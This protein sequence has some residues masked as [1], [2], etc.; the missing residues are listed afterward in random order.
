MRW[1]LIPS[2]AKDPSVAA[3][4]NQC[5]GRNGRHQTRVPRC[6]EIP[7]V[8]DPRRWFL[9]VDAHWE[10]KAAVL[11][12]S[13]RRRVVRVRRIVGSLERPER[14]VGQDLLDFDYDPER[15]DLGRPRPNASDP[16]S[17]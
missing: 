6:A 11:F 16:S 7:Q 9:R 3:S 17:R 8:P 2:W 4:M 15:G 5:T 12:R 13:Q 10:D 1:G 14:T